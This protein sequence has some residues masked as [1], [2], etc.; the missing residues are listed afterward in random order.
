MLSRKAGVP[1]LAMGLIMLTAGILVLVFVPQWG[2]WIG[3]YPEKVIRSQIPAEAQATVKG[4]MQFSLGPLIERIGHTYVK[5]GGYFGGSL[6]TIMSLG[7]TAVG[8]R[9]LS[10]GYLFNSGK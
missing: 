3:D 2:Q 4:M 5:I 8:L 6:L 1:V 10:K 9:L 7:M